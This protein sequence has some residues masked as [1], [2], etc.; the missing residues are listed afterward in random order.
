MVHSVGVG[1]FKNHV[2]Y[3][4][5]LFTIATP[6]VLCPLEVLAAVEFA[7]PGETLVSEGSSTVN[8]HQTLTVP[9]LV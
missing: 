4:D 7:I 5:V 6:A 3:C 8:T 9:S 2:V 1:G